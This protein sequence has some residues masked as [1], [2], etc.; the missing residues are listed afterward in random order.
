MTPALAVRRSLNLAS[1]AA[2]SFCRPGTHETGEDGVERTCQI[3]YHGSGDG[4]VAVDF[5]GVDVDLYEF[6]IRAP[7]A[8]SARQQPVEA[9]AHE[10]HH[11]GLFHDGGAARQSAERAVVGQYA[12]GHR[13]GVVGYA[14]LVDK[15]FELIFDA[16]IGSALADDDGG[17]LCCGEHGDGAVDGFLGRRHGRAEVDRLIEEL[18]GV[19]A[20]HDGA[21]TG[22]GDVEIY[23]AGTARYGCAVGA[24]HSGG[25]VFGLIDAVS[26]FDQGFGYVELVEAFVC[27]LLE[28]DGFA[29]ARTADLNHRVAVD[30]SVGGGGEA[31]EEAERRYCQKH[32]GLAGE[33]AVGGGGHAG[34]LLVAEADKAYAASLGDICEFGHGDAYKAVHRVD[35]DHAECAYQNIHACY[36]CGVGRFGGNCVIGS[37]H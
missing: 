8:V 24:D 12:L 30:S 26:G 22:S 29:Y 21:H 11:V 16:G 13:H 36:L 9:C 23:A 28:V 33:V 18:V 15:S 1:L 35:A 17:F 3:A 31:V 10:H 25:D 14:G 4:S 34:L 19:V 5:L 32:T 37:S 6:G 2:L 7:F 20:V 27:A